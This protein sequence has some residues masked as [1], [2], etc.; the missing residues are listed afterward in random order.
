MMN[1]LIVEDEILIAESL[2]QMLLDMG[3][4]EITTCRKLNKALI[5]LSQKKYDLAILDIN[6]E[7]GFEGIELGKV[8]NEK[9]IPFFYSTSYSDMDTIIK[10]KET[11]PG[12]YVVKPYSPE[13][14]MIAK[15][16][17]LMH[18]DRSKM[19][20]EQFKQVVIQYE[21]SKRESEILTYAIK[22]MSNA[23]IAEKLFLSSNTVKF[24][25]KNIF[26]KTNSQNK[27]DLLELVTQR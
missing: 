26:S 14:I 17:T 18:H 7:G 1:I 23:E 15:E 5:Q 11:L 16:L 4:T 22:R 3:Y 13:E 27:K 6:I 24:H 20:Q 2:K 19:A 21:L 8:C 9:G 10:A 25:L 12:G